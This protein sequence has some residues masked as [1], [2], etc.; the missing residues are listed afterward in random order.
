MADDDPRRNFSIWFTLSL[1]VNLALTTALVVVVLKMV[2]M[3]AVMNHSIEMVLKLLEKKD[4][5]G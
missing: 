4:V 5:W 2:E 1:C 3:A